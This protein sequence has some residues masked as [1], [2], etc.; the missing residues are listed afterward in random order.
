[1]VIEQT[2]RGE[3]AYDI[4]SRLLKDRIVFLGGVVDSDSANLVISQLLFLD[5]DGTDDIFLY[6]NSLGGSVSDGLAIVDT[7]NYIKSKVH[8]V[9]VGTAASMGAVI[10]ACGE[11]G[12]RS[13]LAHSRVLI[14]QPSG[15]TEG[16]ASDIRIWTK[17]MEKVQQSLYELLAQRT[18]QNIKKIE[19]DCDRDFIMSAGEAIKYGL[20]DEILNKR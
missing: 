1:M 16:Q 10:L 6:I 20:C 11:K 19:K 18:G 2:S 17:E 8:T 9:C 3:R 12:M 13:A 14:H 5:S 4:Y 7:M 15:G